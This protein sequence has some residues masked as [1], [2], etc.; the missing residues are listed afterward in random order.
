MNDFSKEYLI[1]D[2]AS[3]E[4]I[5]ALIEG[6]SQ[7]SEDADKAITRHYYDTFDWALYQSGRAL[8]ERRRGDSRS[9][10]L[11]DL[12]GDHP[13][14][15]QSTDSAPGFAW[16][17]GPGTIKDA[18]AEAIT[19]RRLLPMAELT[20]RVHSLRLLDDDEKTVVRL[21]I[22]INRFR[23]PESGREGA[24]SARMRLIPIKGYD[25]EARKA[26][27]LLG[28]L[29]LDV[30]RTPLMLEAL[31]A[32]GK[33]PGA[34]SSKLNYRLDPDK[35]AD[36]TTKEIML[37]LLDTL[38]ANVEGT[39]QN[40]D[41]EF[42][43]DL[44]VACRRTRSALTQ[45]KGVFPDDIVTEYK[46]RFAW[47]QQVTGPVRDL[48]V[49]LLDFD[50][51]RDSLPEVMRGDL[52]P[53]KAYLL[54]HYDTEQ[55]RLAEA[56]A[57][58]RF[59]ALLR[60]WRAFLEAPVP[61][62]SVLTNAMAPSKRVADTRIWKMWRR[63]RKEGRAIGPD[64]P[65]AELHE[66]R[67]SCKKLRYLM[68]FFAS[69]YPKHGV[70]DLIKQIKV[71]LDNLGRFQDFAVQAEHLRDLAHRMNDDGSAEIDT[72]LAMGV[73][74]GDLLGHQQQARVEF[75]ETFGA[76]D[77]AENRD[78]FKQLFAPMPAATAAAEG[79]A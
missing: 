36:A 19:M 70:R 63:V 78:Q 50:D 31:A 37:G 60:D 68:E 13:S 33:R 11:H 62:R 77:S 45:I 6:H 32:A 44:R 71:L 39:R 28:K 46:E 64:S 69:L 38:E 57:S 25:A 52:A 79:K 20:G 8:E 61:E 43:H 21:S 41:S 47:L 24:L 2:G 30:A 76:F 9:L 54:S 17:L 66:L 29:G 23:D 73:L 42:L 16:D 75:A 15:T 55:T 72:L 3:P 22:E 1:P 56:L 12:R 35:R 26:G 74:V 7:F 34:Y 51:Y 10:V 40:L 53:L 59:L 49:Y 18:I 65:A 27:A 4:S 58:E 67:K 14:L 5:R 48:D